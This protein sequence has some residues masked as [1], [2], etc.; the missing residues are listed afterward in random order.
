MNRILE[1]IY[2][3]THPRSNRFGPAERW[4]TLTEESERSKLNVAREAL[5][6]AERLRDESEANWP[7]V[8]KLSSQIDDELLRL[9]LITGHEH[10]VRLEARLNAASERFERKVQRSIDESNAVLAGSRY[11]IVEEFE[12]REP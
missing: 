12:V 4:G 11:P 3:V 6:T 9:G 7:A 8:D 1:W 2:E 10:G 5:A